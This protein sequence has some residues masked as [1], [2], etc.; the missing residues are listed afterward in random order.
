MAVCD[1]ILHSPPREFGGTQIPVKLKAL[2][3]KLLE[4][5]PTN[6]CGSADEAHR[7][8][9]ALETSLAPK[10]PVRLSRATWIALSTAV[11]LIAIVGGWLWRRSVRERWALGTA[12]PEIN[13]LIDAGE[14]LKAA[15]LAREARS[16][17]PNDPTLE[18]FWTVA[19]GE[20]SIASVPSEADV[21]FR[22]YRGNPNAWQPLGKTPLNKVRVPRT[23]YVFRTVKPGFAPVFFIWTP[24]DHLSPVSILT[25]WVSC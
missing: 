6:R 7:E 13:R 11:V 9:R 22:A 24:P 20:V 16:V 19:T 18:K 2:I 5:D 3:L 4:K 23:D 1:A 10:P 14:Y 8:L 25:Y 12:G 21:S 17:L 15:T